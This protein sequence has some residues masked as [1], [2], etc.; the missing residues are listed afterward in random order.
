ML[1]FSCGGFPQIIHS[2]N[3][4]VNLDIYNIIVGLLVPLSDSSMPPPPPPPPPAPPGFSSPG[5][6]S[7]ISST[8]GNRFTNSVMLLTDAIKEQINDVAAK[9]NAQ[10]KQNTVIYC[11][12]ME[13]LKTRYLL[14]SQK[15]KEECKS[16][17]KSPILSHDAFDPHL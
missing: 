14:W 17:Q 5:T 9:K 11:E 7:D 1:F 4:F 15:K 8:V 6:I 10:L 2:F 12:T 16:S 3:A 13:S